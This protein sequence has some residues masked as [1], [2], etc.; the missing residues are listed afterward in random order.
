[1]GG[2]GGGGGGK[3]RNKANHFIYVVTTDALYISI[4]CDHC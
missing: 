2:G 3:P 1:M 4:V